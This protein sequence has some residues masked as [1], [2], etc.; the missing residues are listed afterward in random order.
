[1]ASS[2]LNLADAAEQVLR[3]GPEEALDSRQIAERAIAQGLIAPRSDAPWT[4][5]AAAIRKDSRRRV[6]RGEVPRFEALGG[7]RFKLT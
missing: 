4:Y 6:A 2:R 1:M 5:V 7:G 3:S